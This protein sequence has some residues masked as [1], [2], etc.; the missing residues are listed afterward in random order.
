MPILI[1]LGQTVGAYVPKP[2][3]LVARLSRSLKVIGTDT[4]QSGT[5]DFLLTFH[6][7]YGSIFYSFEY[8]ARWC[9]T[10]I[11]KF[12]TQPLFIATAEGV[13]LGIGWHR[14]GSRN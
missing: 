3:P 1:A 5:Y 6:S 14:M 9:W 11:V 7:N 12:P 2:G 8:I 10:K 4:D 13:P